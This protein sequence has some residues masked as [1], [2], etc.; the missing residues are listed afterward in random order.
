MAVEGMWALHANTMHE[1]TVVTHGTRYSVLTYC[2][3][4][5]ENVSDETKMRLYK[6]GYTLPDGWTPAT[7]P[8]TE[9]LAGEPMPLQADGYGSGWEVDEAPF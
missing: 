5:N 7:A 8:Y 1:V 3:N 2:K 6:T 9:N 4:Y